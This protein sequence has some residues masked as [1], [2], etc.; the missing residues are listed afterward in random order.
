MKKLLPLIAAITILSHYA[1]VISYATE[2]TITP[3]MDKG[4]YTVDVSVFRLAEQ[5]GKLVETLITKPRI[6]S[7][8]GYPSSLYQGLQTN[9]PDYKSQ[10]G[11]VLALA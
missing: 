7:G 8:L 2:A 10:C 11:R 5:H 1:K 4:K 3:I 9:N 6:I